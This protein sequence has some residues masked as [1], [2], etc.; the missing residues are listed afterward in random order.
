MEGGH[1]IDG[2]G[3]SASPPNAAAH[4]IEQPGQVDHLGLQGGVVDHRFAVGQSGGHHQGL[5]GADARAVE[6]NV[7]TGEALAA[8][9]HRG[10]DHPMLNG[11]LGAERLQPLHVFH[12]RSAAD[13]TAPGQ[14]HLGGAHPGEERADAEEA[15]PQAIHQ[16]VWGCGLGDVLA[17]E[18][19]ALPLA[20]DPHTEGRQDLPHGGDVGEGG[21]VAEPQG[22]AAE[23]AGGHQHQGRILGAADTELSGEFETA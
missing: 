10:G 17:V 19:D 20:G 1:P 21:H 12:H 22:V 15:G 2:D 9:R 18:I 7:T 8:A 3:G 16:F 23:Q 6:V 5:R 11:D 14:G 4:G 13:L